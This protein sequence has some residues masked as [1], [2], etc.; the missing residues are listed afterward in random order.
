LSSQIQHRSSFDRKHYFYADLPAGYQITQHFSK[1]GP[2]EQQFDQ[3]YLILRGIDPIAKGGYLDLIELDGV[4]NKKRVHLHQ[5]Q[6]EQVFY[7]LSNMIFL[8]LI[9]QCR[10]LAN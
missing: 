10:I 5:I 2:T 1:Y 8:S 9:A 7:V 3:F 4:S 6:L